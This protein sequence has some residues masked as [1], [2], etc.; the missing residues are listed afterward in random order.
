MELFYSSDI[1]GDSVILDKDESAHCV[2]VLRHKAGDTIGVIDGLGNLYRCRLTS[3]DALSAVAGIE[4]V[5]KG[6]G[7][8]PYRLEMAVCPTKNIDR[9][10]WFCEK[11]VEIGTDA[12]IPV[13][14]DRSERKS[15]KKDR[16]ER[17]ALS[18]A[19]QSLKGRIPEIR[20]SVSVRDYIISAPKDALRMIAYCHDERKEIDEI[21]SS[22]RNT[23]DIC[24]LIGP[25]GDFSEEEI[26]L[27]LGN[28]WLPVSL[29]DS[30]L[31]TE[32]AG[33][34]ACTAVYLNRK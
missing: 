12:I 22:R 20:D 5:E 3:A 18:A 25:E 4:S 28:G 16:L 2:R 23:D 27:A 32:T 9:Y 21:L 8:H 33:V 7:A 29:G 1:N 19:K 26:T 6:F 13:V 11:A 30:R 17:L 34:V 10:E 14:G 31:R 15:V 24:I